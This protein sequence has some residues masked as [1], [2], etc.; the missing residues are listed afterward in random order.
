MPLLG[1][2]AEVRIELMMPAKADIV[3]ERMNSDDFGPVDVD[4]ARA[5]GL[6]IAAGRLDPVAEFGLRQD[7]AEDDRRGD[8]PEQRHVDAERPDVEVADKESGEPLVAGAPGALR[9]AVG[10]EQRG[11]AHDEEHAERDEEGWNFQPRDEQAVDQA[12]Q[13]RDDEGDDEGDVQR[14]DALVEE[15]PHHD[16]G[17]AEQRADRE[18]ELAGRH[19]ERHGQRDQP[20]LDGEGE[21]VAD[22]ERRTGRR[23]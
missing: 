13:R 8:E 23:G 16:R 17:E 14:H 21:R 6:G 5:R 7:I 18:V 12:D 4:A 10:D 3:A 2:A 15:R 19:E 9:E 11:A 1:L 22:V 20:E